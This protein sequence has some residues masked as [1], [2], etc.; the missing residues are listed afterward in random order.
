MNLGE[1]V[2]GATRLAQELH[3]PHVERPAK[4]FARAQQVSNADADLPERG[5]RDAETVRRPGSGLKRHATLGE[6]ERLVVPVLHERHVRPISADDG[7]DVVPALDGESLGMAQ[8]RHR[9]VKA[10]VLGKR[11]T[12]ERVSQREVV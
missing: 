1:A 3:A 6:R 12:R 8:R 2:D 4:Q 11:D 10:S 5:K 7:D 9:L